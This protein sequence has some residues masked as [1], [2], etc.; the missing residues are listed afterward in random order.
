ME[1]IEW[2]LAKNQDYIDNKR[3]IEKLATKNKIKFDD[4]LINKVYVI[5]ELV[6]CIARNLNKRSQEELC[7]KILVKMHHED[8]NCIRLLLLVMNKS[9]IGYY[10]SKK[11]IE[12]RCNI[13]INGDN[14]KFNNFFI[15]CDRVNDNGR[16]YRYNSNQELRI[17]I[18]DNDNLNVKITHKFDTLNRKINLNY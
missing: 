14:G 9:N 12:H 1:K 17:K 15:V 2:N 13:V 7:D 4:K 5:I 3:F 8:I 10:Y 18:N 11:K 16:Y 6:E